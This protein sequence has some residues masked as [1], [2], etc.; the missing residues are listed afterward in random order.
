MR[1]YRRDRIL[2]SA[3]AIILG[4]ILLIWPGGSL[5][6]LGRCIGLILLAGGAVSAVLFL[7]DRDSSVRAFL[8]VMAA[9]MILSGIAIIRHP[10]D[11]IKLIPTCIGVLVLFSGI[12]NLGETF[13][14]TKR[15]YG[16][17]WISL[18]G[19]AVTVAVGL[20]LITRAFGAAA[21]ITRIAGA[22]LTACG[23]K[24]LLVMRRVSSALRD[25][26]QKIV[27]VDAVVIDETK[28]CPK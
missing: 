20:L 12:V 18:L 5:L 22:V 7:T 2:F 11:L 14:L 17:W 10:D 23:V 19:A 16:R 13:T 21:F 27:D 1:S 28:D 3:G 24:D 9:V 25:A 8:M 15:K 26:E 6:L 4:L